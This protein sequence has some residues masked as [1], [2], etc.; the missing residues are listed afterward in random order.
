MKKHGKEFIGVLAVLFLA[1]LIVMPAAADDY[2]VGLPPVTVIQDSVEG[3]FD[4]YMVDTWTSPDNIGNEYAEAEF[5]VPEAAAEDAVFARLYV[6]VY[7]GNMT[8]DY[9]GN[10]TV[11]INDNTLTNLYP[12]DLHYVNTTGIVY[13]S[14]LPQGDFINLSR[15]T[16]DYLAVFDVVDYIDSEDI[17]VEVT[18]TNESEKFDGRIKKVELAIAYENE[19]GYTTKYWVNEGQDPATYYDNGYVGQTWFN[20]VT[21]SGTLHNVTVWADP[22]ASSY[23][24]DGQY[25]WNG[26]NITASKIPVVGITN[27]AGLDKWYLG[28]G[29]LLTN[30]YLSYQRSGSWY[31]L[32]LAFM[33]IRFS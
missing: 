20:G 7:S 26:A 5:E 12:L 29:D 22:I 27:Q 30:N 21:Y 10:L 19:E 11:E 3:D 4:V 17:T 15:T 16:S 8:A 18:T 31:K 14:N 23:S 25:D 28:S 9:T 24:K 13:D 1:A 6:V 33:K 32:P 2:W